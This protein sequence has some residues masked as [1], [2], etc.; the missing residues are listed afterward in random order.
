MRNEDER[1]SKKEMEEDIFKQ[2]DYEEHNIYL[3]LLGS[4]L[5]AR[6]CLRLEILAAKWL[7][8]RILYI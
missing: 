1:G 6:Q 8:P 4:C 5:Y 3:F 2:N 7:I